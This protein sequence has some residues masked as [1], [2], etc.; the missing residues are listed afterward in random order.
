MV[1]MGIGINALGPGWIDLEFAFD[2]AFTQQDGYLHAGMIATALDSACGYA[3][4]SL[5]PP[6]TRVLTAEYKINLLR[7]ARGA[8]FVAA[9]AVVKPGRTLT[10]TQATLHVENDNKPLAIMTGTIMA[11]R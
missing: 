8:S 11:L 4:M 9:A 2:E 7:P 3:A 6:G 1:S 5:T 10:V